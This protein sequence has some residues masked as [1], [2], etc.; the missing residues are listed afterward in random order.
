MDF[1]PAFELAADFVNNTS[2]PIFLTGKAGTGKTT[3]LKYIREH[4]RK[5][6]VVVA[7]T[8]VAAINAGGVTMHSFFQLPFGP[9]IPVT[10]SSQNGSVTDRLSLFQNMKMG[11]DKRELIRD[12]QLLI[13]DEVS[14][15]RCDMLD[16]MDA[17]LR[18]FRKKPHL[19]FGGVQVLFIGDLYQLPPVMPDGEWMILRDHYKSPFFFDSKALTNSSLVYIELKKIYR[20]NEQKFIDILN[21]IRNNQIEQSDLRTLNAR[22]RVEP[23]PGKKYITLTSHNYKADKINNEALNNLQGKL[24]QFE[25]S[26]DGEFPEKALPTDIKLQ[27]K[28]GAQ[29]MFLR[30]DKS[31]EKRFYNGKLASVVQ[32]DKDGVRVAMNDHGDE[33]QLEKEVW[34]NIKY[35]YNPVDEK[36]E[37]EK[38]GSFSQ[39]PIRLAWAITI[40]KS[41][42]LTFENAIIDAGDSFAPGQVYVALSRCVS[43]E[44]LILHS[45]IDPECISTHDAVIEFS[46]SEH[47]EEKLGQILQQEKNVFRNATL[48]ETFDLSNLIDF[49]EDHLSRMRGKT[50]AHIPSAIP[51]GV[52]IVKKLSEMQ[53][54]AMK[55][56]GQLEQLLKE[57][58]LDKIK[59]R[60]GKAIDYF[61][62]TM[63]QWLGL[64]DDEIANVKKQKKVKKYT[65]YI[66]ELKLE[67]VKRIHAIE[68][69]TY[70]DVSL[71]N[72]E[73]RVS[74]EQ[75]KASLDKIKDKVEKGDSQNETLAL[76]RA[77]NSI[78][79]IAEMRGLATSTIESH[80]ATLIRTGEVEVEKVVEKS[81]LEKILEVL[82]DKDT[83]FLST[84]KAKLGSDYSYGE[85]RAVVKHL[86]F[87]QSRKG[88]TVS[89]KSD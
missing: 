75:E 65:K 69:A 15:V 63:T 86:E 72:T 88:N 2:C 26:I 36:I 41:Q 74:I 43:L 25:G 76:F 29:V 81:K 33:L 47:P 30:N 70:G 19:L 59:D 54:V 87:K 46:N 53:A 4:T 31:E 42:G 22:Y 18:H 56:K 17:I 71:S 20:Q 85:I 67:V 23:A 14:M 3:F 73:S 52:T 79:Q 13:I 62:S 80:L 48:I 78:Y 6:C 28:V 8:G 49:V 61:S 44:G 11:S 82:Q 64:F 16:A 50:Y 21:R 89:D 39:Y 68:H 27:L 60:S 77:G 40:H 45:R 5:K 84:A 9:Y 34:E 38:L 10:R 35:S 32:I 37:E 58:D 57:N 83:T 51:F 55:F 7:P 66:K 1:N 12:L 24:Y